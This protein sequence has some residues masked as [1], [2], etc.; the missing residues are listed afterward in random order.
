VLYHCISRVVERRFAF[1][2]GAKEKFRTLMRMTE[3]FSGCRVLSYC[4]LDNHFHLLLEVPPPPEEG[5]SEPELLRRLAA[6]YGRESTTFE[7]VRFELEKA[8]K[9]LAGE[10]AEQAVAEIHARYTH[11]MHDLSGF[12]N[13]LLLR[14]S[15]WFNRAH[16]RTGHLWEDRFKSVLVDCGTA[17]RTIAAYIDLNPVRAGICDDPALYRWSGY[18]EALGGGAKG[19]GTKAREGL[20]RAFLADEEV[21]FD[22]TRWQEIS[23]RYRRLL[24]LALEKRPVTARMAA[25]VDEAKRKRAPETANMNTEEMLASGKTHTV[26]GEIGMAGVLCHRVRYFT[27]G[28]VIGSRQFVDEFFERSRERFGPRRKSGARRMRGTAGEAA[29]KELWAVRDLRE[30]VV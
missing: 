23:L 3:N 11:R 8:R 22:A 16:E 30:G 1:D 7:M 24:G 27:E 4:I 13:T 20:V 28:A 14:F 21:G 19:A 25:K 17:A 12:M 15:K 29:G 26:L 2:S 5:I 9:E 10:A 6:L 18:G